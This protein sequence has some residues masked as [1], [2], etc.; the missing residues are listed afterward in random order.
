MSSTIAKDGLVALGLAPRWPGLE[1]ALSAWNDARTQLCWIE[2]PPVLEI[3]RYL[4]RAVQED[5][6]GPGWRCAWSPGEVLDK[7]LL[8]LL[9][10]RGALRR[11]IEALAAL[12]CQIVGA[13]SAQIRFDVMAQ[14][15]CPR[16]HVD[17]VRARLLCTY[18]GEGT[19]W[20]AE[21]DMDR[22]RL[23]A[24]SG[25]LCD[26]RSGLLLRPDAIR[27]LPAFAVAL[28]KGR[29]WPANQARGAVHRS[30]PV[31]AHAAPRVMVAID[32]L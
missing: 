8:P 25:G 16:F 2:R 23:G 29:Q 32:A 3:A 5:L 19:Q 15:Q 12:L 27:T 1:Q 17:N 31:A 24:G 11:D 10:G 7:D 22:A 21:V 9:R 30:P 28:L 14:A 13:R 26:E 20:L 18:R 4:D 6:L